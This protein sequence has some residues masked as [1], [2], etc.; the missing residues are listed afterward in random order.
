MGLAGRFVL[1]S[2]RMPSSPVM[3][4]GEL[5]IFP[6]T[7]S[8]RLGDKFQQEPVLFKIPLSFRRCSVVNRHW[9]TALGAASNEGKRIR[10]WHAV[11]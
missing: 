4:T 3:R 7:P 8:H 1:F 5:S 2:A 9:A 10:H 6:D 11:L